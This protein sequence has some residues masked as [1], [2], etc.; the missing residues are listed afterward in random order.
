VN[1]VTVVRVAEIEPV[2]AITDDGDLVAY[3]QLTTPSGDATN[4]L[5]SS[6]AIACKWSGALLEIAD[7]LPQ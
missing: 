7:A 4:V 2:I 5:I 3:L 6:K 1:N